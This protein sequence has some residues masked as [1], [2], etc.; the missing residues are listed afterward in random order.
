MQR[1]GEQQ[2][3]RLRRVFGGD[4]VANI[5]VLMVS[6]D[7]HVHIKLHFYLTSPP[8]H[9]SPP[10]SPL[11]RQP[12][13]DHAEYLPSP[14]AD[15][16]D[17]LSIPAN[18][19]SRTCPWNVLFCI[20]CRCFLYNVCTSLLSGLYSSISLY[21]YLRTRQ[22]YRLVKTQRSPHHMTPCV[23]EYASHPSACISPH[24]ELE[25]GR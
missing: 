5:F 9:P 4:A 17:R 20:R 10:S 21:T 19:L 16:E 1:D 13:A 25:A 11:S 15:E 23:F 3:F 2:C 18:Q 6:V 14:G 24:L 7:F 8:S 22:L 12:E